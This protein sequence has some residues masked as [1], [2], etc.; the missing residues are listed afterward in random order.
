[1]IRDQKVTAILLAGGSGT[2][3]GA[4]GNK[5]YVEIGGK[6]ILQYSLEVLAGHPAVDECIFVVKDGEQA[7]AGE[8]EKRMRESNVGKSYAPVRF[9]TGGSTRQESVY[10]GLQEASGDIVV[11]H[12][13]ARPVIRTSYV[14]QC[15]AAMEEVPGASIGVRSKDTIKLTDDRGIVTTTTV[16]ANTWI[17]QTPQCFHM[18]VLKAAHERFADAPGITDD[19]SILELAG[20]P[21]KMLLGDYTNIKVTTPEDRELAEAFLN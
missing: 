19:C 13:G 18:G 6:P 10:H 7:I 2:R 15:L 21:V 9:V 16:R 20:L 1:M 14:D 12:D 4:S 3:F 8:L 11:I 17:V 5:V